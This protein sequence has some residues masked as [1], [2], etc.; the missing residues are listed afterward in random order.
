MKKKTALTLSAIALLSAGITFGIKFKQKKD[1]EK[2]LKTV[3]I[4]N[5]EKELDSLLREDVALKDSID[6]YEALLLQQ[7]SSMP[8]NLEFQL[9]NISKTLRSM[10]LDFTREFE[11]TLK[12]MEPYYIGDGNYDLPDNLEEHY[13]YLLGG[14]EKPIFKNF[15]RKDRPEL[16]GGYQW[17]VGK[18]YSDII[19]FQDIRDKGVY[20]NAYFE[21]FRNEIKATHGKF[22]TEDCVY[23]ALTEASEIKQLLI[24]IKY[25]INNMDNS[26]QIINP[27]H[28]KTLNK[29]I[30]D[31]IP[32]IEKQADLESA[33][34]RKRDSFQYA[35]WEIKDRIYD[36]NK[37]VK[38]LKTD[39]IAKLMKEQ[40]EK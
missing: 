21:H 15:D 12:Q 40:K 7:Q 1:F 17:Y 19:T 34:S 3:L 39:D 26:K 36:Q 31:A 37:K 16:P 4:P 30:D 25:F 13:H 2:T 22:K 18:K 38:N 29:Q 28:I 6:Y 33:T 24:A 35:K 10:E 11:K 27:E 8:H 9:S 5:A 23:Y 32:V 20:S 14:L